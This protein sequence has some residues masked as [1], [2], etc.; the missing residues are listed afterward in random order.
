M[1]SNLNTPAAL[2]L[3]R[4]RLEGLKAYGGKCACCG[5]ARAIFLTFDHIDPVLRKTLNDGASAKLHKELASLRKRGW[6]Q[7]NLQVMCMNCNY[8]KGKL[9]ICEHPEATVDDLLDI[10]RRKNHSQYALRT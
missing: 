5:E 7:E 8:A 9:V 2:S 3:F 6:P 4:L 1:Y 10:V